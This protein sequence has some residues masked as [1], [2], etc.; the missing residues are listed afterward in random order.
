MRNT[1]VVWK[2]ESTDFT[3]SVTEQFSAWILLPKPVLAEFCASR[4]LSEDNIVSD[5][6]DYETQNRTVIRS[7]PDLETATAFVEACGGEA[8]IHH[9]SRK[10]DFSIPGIMVELTVVPE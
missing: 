4:N 7:W 2:F 9:F 10:T 1:K 8:S 5:I 6:I 3:E